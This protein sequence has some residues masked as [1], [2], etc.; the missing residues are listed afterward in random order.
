M[1]EEQFSLLFRRVCFLGCFLGV[2][3]TVFFLAGWAGYVG[4]LIPNVLL[5]GVFIF[6]AL[7]FLYIFLVF[8]FDKS[9]LGSLLWIF[10][11]VVLVTEVIL[12]LVPPTARDELTHHLAVPKL[13]ASAGKILEIPFDY[14]S[15]YPM[16]VDMLFTPWIQWGWDFA[17]KLIHGL[18][19]FLIGLLLYCYLGSRLGPIYGLS[20]FFFFISLPAVLR[21][22]NWAYV[23]LALAFYSTASLLCLLQ[24]TQNRN[25]RQWLILSGLAAGFS[26]ATK[27]NGFLVLLLLVFWVGLISGR[28]KKD[29]VEEAIRAPAFFLFFALIPVTPWLLRNF[30]WTGNAFYP[31]FSALF[32]GG[33]SD[34]GGGGEPELGILA[35]RH[36]LYGESGWQIAALPMRIFFTGQ[37]DNPQYFDGVLN[38]IL[39]LGLPWAFKGR[40]LEEKK[41]LFGFVALYFVFALFLADL[42]IRYILPIVPPL[43]ILLVYGIHNAYLR[44]AHPFI[45]VAALI[46]LSALNGIYLKD[47]FHTVAPIDYLSGAESREAYLTGQLPDYP[48]FQFVNQNLPA[49]ARI[50]LI[51]MGRR[52]YYCD[53]PY[54]HDGSENPWTLLQAIQSAQNG[55]G[56]RS[57][58]LERKLTHLLVRQDLLERFLDNNLTPHQQ[59]VWHSFRTQSSRVLYK[60]RGYSIYQIHG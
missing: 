27:P 31:F 58:L 18:F 24:W 13:Y 3:A 45:L 56:I 11:L 4:S 26:A 52:V 34:A 21:L 44:L 12:G 33:S 17:P 30:V 59:R 54:Y 32:G 28:D 29:G 39:I 60:D 5:A 9:F 25:S 41:I 20:G 50:Y 46:V 57:K 43:V 2:V 7:Y 8:L 14:P 35:K 40:R 6:A 55:D 23:D 42:R 22:S 38:P 37:D 19:A 51:F 48:V 10:I 53:R 49:S 1:R 36:L 15:Y 47:Y 16:L